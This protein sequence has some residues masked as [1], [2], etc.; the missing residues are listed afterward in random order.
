MYEKFKT[1]ID[2][3]V[4]NRLYFNNRFFVHKFVIFTY[5]YIPFLKQL[6][7]FETHF[8]ELIE[9]KEII[10]SGKKT[11]THKQ[12]M[13]DYDIL[14]DNIVN[15]LN[16]Y[17]P[18]PDLSDIYMYKK[19]TYNKRNYNY[20]YHSFSSNLDCERHGNDNYCKDFSINRQNFYDYHSKIN[21]S[22]INSYVASKRVPITTLFDYKNAIFL[23]HCLNYTENEQETL[24]LLKSIE[25]IAKRNEFVCRLIDPLI[26][27]FC[28][29][30]HP[31]HFLFCQHCG[32]IMKYAKTKKYCSLSTDK[33]NCAKSARNKTYYSNKLKN[34]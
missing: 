21:N 10:K 19:V 13:D 12:Y 34:K 15:E 2:V 9:N 26:K 24:K 16:K 29:R 33:K 18:N 32:Q 8:G 31:N 7:R 17:C 14:Q 4:T 11:T 28:F 5:L 1:D 6:L 20:K 27:S 30:V 25:E 22:F 3:K 23:L